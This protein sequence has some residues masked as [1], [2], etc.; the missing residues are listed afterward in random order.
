M[1]LAIEELE[2]QEDHA[3]EIIQRKLAEVE[4]AQRWV[5]TYQEQL[6]EALK[7]YTEAIAR[8]ESIRKALVVLRDHE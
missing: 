7:M 3:D 4:R 1:E 8:K 2:W 5:G 6:T